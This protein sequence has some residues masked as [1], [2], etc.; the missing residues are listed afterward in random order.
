MVTSDGGVLTLVR[1]RVV[2]LSGAEG[3]LAG[4]HI[5]AGHDFPE[6]VEVVFP[7][8]FE[9]ARE[10]FK[11]FYSLFEGL[12]A[13]CTLEFEHGSP[14][15]AHLLVLTQGFRIGVGRPGDQ[16]RPPFVVETNQHLSRKVSTV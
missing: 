11:V 6:L 9:F 10:L 5:Q 2:L 13:G 8:P 16:T 12:N 15:L 14:I 3:L 4:S 7:L 1:D